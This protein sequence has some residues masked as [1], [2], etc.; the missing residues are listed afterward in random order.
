[1]IPKKKTFITPE[2]YLEI[3]RKAGF[4]SEY[5]N[6]EMFALAGAGKTHNKISSNLIINIGAHLKNKSCLIYGSDMKVKIKSSGLYT[7]PDISV[8]CGDEKFEDDESDILLNPKLVI[9]ILSESTESYDR[10]KKFEHY[11]TLESL[12]EYVLVSQEKPKV[13]QFLKQPDDK[14]LYSEVNGI[15]SIVPLSS[16]ECEIDL[17]EIYHKVEFK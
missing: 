15:D 11:R 10:G 9:E 17:K 8:V 2:E 7:Y 6:G 14:W 16:I 4:K 3:E 1:M 12:Q 13:E 5:F